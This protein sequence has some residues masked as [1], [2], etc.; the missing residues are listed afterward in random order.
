MHPAHVPFVG[1]AKAVIFRC[2]CDLRPCGG[3][4]RN[5]DRAVLTAADDGIQMLEEFNCVEVSV[6]A[7]FV[8]DPFAVLAAIVQIQ[9]GRN[10]IHTKSVNVIIIEPVQCVSDHEVQ[11]FIAGVVKALCAPVRM[12]AHS[13]ICIFIGRLAV[14]V[15]KTV[16]IF[17]EMC[18]Y[19][20]ENDADVMHMEIIHQI[21]E[22][23]RGSVTCC[24]RI[25]S[26]YLISPGAVKRIFRN[27]HQFNMRI[28]HPFAVFDEFMGKL[29]IVQETVLIVP[30]AFLPGSKVNFINC[31]R[32]FKRVLFGTLFHPGIVFPVVSVNDRGTAG[33]CRTQFRME[34]I[35]ISLIQDI[36]LF[37]CNRILVCFAFLHSFNETFKDTALFQRNHV[38]CGGIPCITVTDNGNGFCV[39]S[40]YRKMPSLLPI[41]HCRMCTHFL[42]DLIVSSL[43]EQIPVIFRQENRIKSRGRLVFGNLFRGRFA[44]C[45][46]RRLFRLSC[47]YSLLCRLLC[48]FCFLRRRSLFGGLLLRLCL[49]CFLRS[50]GGSLLRRFYFLFRFGLLCGSVD[51]TLN[52][53][54]HRTCIAFCFHSHI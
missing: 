23:L 47:F 17:R 54:F 20:V 7:V 45:F 16:R 39:R 40:P 19:P 43:T 10:R 34:C 4:F 14:K 1:E 9:H 30:V 21:H 24:R 22:F 37:G 27:T 28:S 3:F 53:R 8:R 31:H 36:S 51:G 11:D 35:R 49:H 46:L 6:S 18:R 13:R 38:I 41:K 44:R 29:G 50:F 42:V 33:S 15:R 12:F 52:R 5:D 25:I 26:G 48:R 32:L 2:R